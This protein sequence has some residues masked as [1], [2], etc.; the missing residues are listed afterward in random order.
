MDAVVYIVNADAIIRG[1]NA[2]L[3]DQFAGPREDLIDLSF[4]EAFVEA[5]CLYIWRN[6]S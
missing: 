2:E 5:P 1:R 6:I 3:K 4:D